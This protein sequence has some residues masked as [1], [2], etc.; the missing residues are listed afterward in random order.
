[1][2]THDRERPEAVAGPSDIAFLER[3]IEMALEAE[4]RGKKQHFDKLPCGTRC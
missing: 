4:N 2:K 1:M 3:A